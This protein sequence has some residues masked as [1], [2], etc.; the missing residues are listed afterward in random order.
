MSRLR[1]RSSLCVNV[2]LI[3]C[4]TFSVRADSHGSP[5][6]FEEAVVAWQ[7]G[8]LLHRYGQLEPAMDMYRK[9]IALHP[10][11]E[12]HTYLGWAMS[13]LGRLDDAIAQCKK[14][15]EVDPEFGNPYNDIGAYLIELGRPQEAV[16]WFER[17][18]ASKRYCCYFFAHFNLGRVLLADGQIRRAKREF[19][20]ALEVEPNYLPAQRALEFLEQK[21]IQS[22]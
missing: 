22:L 5:E 3:L 20:R 1:L 10:T 4:L 8:Y 13:H 16:P 6:A 9:S 2:G 19:E 21:G 18:I 17:A 14:A 15:I 7:T 12:A 11:A